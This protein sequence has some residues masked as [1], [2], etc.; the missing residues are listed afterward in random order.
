MHTSSSNNIRNLVK[1]GVTLYRPRLKDAFSALILLV[2]QQER[3]PARKNFCFKTPWD[4][5]SAYPLKTL[6]RD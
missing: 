2:G 5:G 1:I 4:G 3:H 6:R